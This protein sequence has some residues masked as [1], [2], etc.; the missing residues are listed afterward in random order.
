MLVDAPTTPRHDYAARIA[1][2]EPVARRVHHDAS[3]RQRLD[4]LRTELDHARERIAALEACLTRP[5]ETIA[6][7]NEMLSS[8]A[9]AERLNI[10]R[11]TVHNRRKAGELLGLPT[12]GG[13]YK[14]PAWQVNDHGQMVAGLK[15]VLAA[16]PDAPWSAHDFLTTQRP[17]LAG[18]APASALQAGDTDA[19]H[20]LLHQDAQNAY[21]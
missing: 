17:E 4:A 1:L 16:F 20:T 19:V 13:A 6:N 9:M 2:G 21:L 3:L 5:A 15:T 14:F 12:S 7:R 10:V 8:D 18:R 11:A